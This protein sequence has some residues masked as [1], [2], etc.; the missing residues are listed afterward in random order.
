M[1]QRGRDGSSKYTHNSL[2][3][4]CCSPFEPGV[5]DSFPTQPD[6]DRLRVRSGRGPRASVRSKRLLICNLPKSPP[7]L[8]ISTAVRAPERKNKRKPNQLFFSSPPSD[9]PNSTKTS[10]GPC[11]HQRSHAVRFGHGVRRN[12][13]AQC[14]Q[15]QGTREGCARSDSQ[16]Q[17]RARRRG[18][19]QRTMTSRRRLSSRKN[20]CTK[21]N[22]NEACF[23]TKTL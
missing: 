13:H 5:A 22:L 3:S 21:S 4:C 10:N 15:H 11:H 6:L 1:W 12:G 2:S 8:N 19:G 9:P 17:T 16:G 7:N 18:V 20:N 14:S 23:N